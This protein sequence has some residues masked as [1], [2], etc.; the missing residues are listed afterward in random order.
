MSVDEKSI[1]AEDSPQ[2]RQFS[3]LFFSLRKH[4][5]ISSF[6]TW[7][8]AVLASGMI[9]FGFQWAWTQEI[10]EE[11][12]REMRLF[13]SAVKTESTVQNN[14]QKITVIPAQVKTRE[15]TILQIVRDRD[16][17]AKDAR[18]LAKS[19]QGIAE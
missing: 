14:D 7:A 15:D 12:R 10:R 18:E 16:K 19:I 1:P 8:L 2:M 17:A 9:I 13:L 5:W 4:I 3:D 6:V 11:I